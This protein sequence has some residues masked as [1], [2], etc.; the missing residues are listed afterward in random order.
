VVKKQMTRIIW[1]SFDD[2]EFRELW[3]ML[4]DI[5]FQL[6][7]IDDYVHKKRLTEKEKMHLI[8]AIIKAKSAVQTIL[9][10]FDIKASV[11]KVGELEACE[12]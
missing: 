5:G 9:F 3:R 1:I 6:E 8:E 10:L 12:R 11:H 7:V 2:G 4:R